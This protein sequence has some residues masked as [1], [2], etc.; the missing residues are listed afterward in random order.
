[1][2]RK[3]L[4]SF[5]FLFS[6]AACFCASLDDQV[7]ISSSAS[8]VNSLPAAKGEQNYFKTTSNY[9]FLS[10]SAM[11]T[12]SLGAEGLFSAGLFRYIIPYE[13]DTETHSA[14]NMLA[15]KFKYGGLTLKTGR[16]FYGSKN[17][18]TPYYGLYDNYFGVNSSALKGYYGAADLTGWLNLSAVYGNE[19]EHYFSDGEGKVSGAVLAVRPAA[20]FELAPFAYK[21]TKDNPDYMY[22]TDLRLYGAYAD[23]NLNGRADLYISYAENAGA[24][25]YYRPLFGKDRLDFTGS[26]WL[27]KFNSSSETRDMF[28]NLRFLYLN[29]SGDDIN[30][31]PF[32]A[33]HPFIDLGSI[34]T[35]ANF[36]QN[37]DA[38]FFNRVHRAGGA[39]RLL[40]YNIGASAIPKAAK[41]LKLDF[42]VYS[43]ADTSAFLTNSSIGGEVDAGAT[44]TPFKNL[45]LSVIYARFYPGQ[46]F[47]DQFMLKYVDVGTVTQLA[48]KAVLK[49]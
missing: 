38:S 14:I 26:A 21:L 32:T 35:G 28:Y 48:F 1:M 24:Y 4:L 31:T 46:G 43:Y 9:I 22:K 40:A 36:L 17:T 11:L 44:V 41:F 12:Q 7:W 47:K 33:I 8:L 29:S 5:I 27:I 37:S 45:D 39:D 16:I 2:G 34:F 18:L 15:A 19:T 30:K 6:A 25:K 42:D 13:N 23:I 49:F 20:G 3:P 10:T